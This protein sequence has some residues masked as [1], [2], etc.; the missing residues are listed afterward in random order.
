MDV[1]H[2]RADAEHAALLVER[3]FLARVERRAAGG[4]VGVGQV[5]AVLHFNNVSCI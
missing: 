4:E 5:G 2:F 3:G 1:G